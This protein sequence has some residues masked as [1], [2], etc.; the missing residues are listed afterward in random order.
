MASLS[1]DMTVGFAA[2]DQ[3]FEA[4]SPKAPS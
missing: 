1:D 4:A 2:V 3:R